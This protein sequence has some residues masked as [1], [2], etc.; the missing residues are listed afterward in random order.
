MDAGNLCGGTAVNA[1]RQEAGTIMYKG[2]LSSHLKDHAKV[3]STVHALSTEVPDYV[4]PYFLLMS[5]DAPTDVNHVDGSFLGKPEHCG[6]VLQPTC[7]PEDPDLPNFLGTLPLRKTPFVLAPQ[8]QGR[9][10][11]PKTTTK[12]GKGC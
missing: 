6:E 1:S 9:L 2:G 11:S 7:T 5:A 8:T 10:D 12:I 4:A 3:F